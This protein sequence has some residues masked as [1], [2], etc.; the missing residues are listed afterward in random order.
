MLQPQIPLGV[1]QHFKGGLYEVIGV[2]KLVDSMDCFVVYRPLYG[3]RELVVRPYE[4]FMKIVFREGR[5][6]PRFQLVQEKPS[7]AREASTNRS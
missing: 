1:Y 7:L 5:E 4:D 3:D 2:A 6:Q